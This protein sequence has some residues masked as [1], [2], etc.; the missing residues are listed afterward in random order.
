MTSVTKRP[1]DPVVIT[2]ELPVEQE[3]LLDHFRID[4]RPT[5]GDAWTPFVSPIDNTLRFYS[6]AAGSSD[7]LFRV[8]SVG[9][10]QT[11]GEQLSLIID[12]SVPPPANS[13]IA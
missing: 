3:A 9:S 13:Q 5:T 1:G 11:P 2:W 4:T 10:Y 7:A 6:F 8:V 12:L